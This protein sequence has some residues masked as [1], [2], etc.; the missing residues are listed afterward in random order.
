M[1]SKLCCTPSF[2]F[3]SLSALVFSAH[4]LH[5]PTGILNKYCISKRNLSNVWPCINSPVEPFNISLSFTACCAA[6]THQSHSQICWYLNL[7]QQRTYAHLISKLCD[8]FKWYNMAWTSAQDQMQG[9]TRSPKG[10]SIHIHLP[11]YWG[12]DSFN[13][14][15]K[16]FSKIFNV[17]Y[18]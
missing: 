16:G 8:W 9:D 2:I 4:A 17:S 1:Y 15:P 12:P 11:S 18:S 3:D 13:L 7:H 6:G 14:C 10:P 5:P